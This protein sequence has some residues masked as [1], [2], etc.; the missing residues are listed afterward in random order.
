MGRRLQRGD[1]GLAAKGADCAGMDRCAAIRANPLQ[2]LAAHRAML[3][4]DR[5]S[6]VAIGKEEPNFLDEI[7]LVRRAV[8]IRTKTAVQKSIS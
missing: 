7:L 1:I 4:A 6:L 8:G 2:Q 3:P 5:I